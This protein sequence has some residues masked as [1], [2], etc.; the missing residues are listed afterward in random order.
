MSDKSLQKKSLKH[1]KMLNDTDKSGSIF[2]QCLL[3]P[4][5]KTV[6]GTHIHNLVKHLKIKHAEF[7]NQNIAMVKDKNYPLERQK[8]LQRFVEIVTV[9][10]RP[11]RYLLDSG[12][13]PFYETKLFKLKAAGYGINLIGDN[14]GVVKAEIRVMA[15]RIRELIERE[16][17]DKCISIMAD[18][19]TKNNKSFL[20]IDIQSVINGVVVCRSIGMVHLQKRHTSDYLLE[21]LNDCLKKYAI[22][23][24]QFVSMT[25]DNGRNMKKS[26]RDMN[27]LPSLLSTAP[28]DL[29]EVIDINFEVE[30][31]EV[32]I[33]K[34]V[35][36]SQQTDDQIIDEML[37]SD[38][39]TILLGEFAKKFHIEAGKEFLYINDVNCCV[40]TMQLVMKD[41]FKKLPKSDENIISLCRVGAKF[42]RKETTQQELKAA[43]IDIKQI[44][45]DV[46]TRFCSKIHMVSK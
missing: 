18:I 37:A 34:I 46:P 9:N 13:V 45:L 32:V 12:F 35:E 6:R 44:R 7:Y 38:D 30:D 27:E 24:S 16:V 36:N 28:I 10:G 20:G 40:H 29:E 14:F 17:K 2:Y 43:G 5:V 4:G 33:Q 1:F 23:V 22:N 19:G 21:V 39:Y 41:A 8:L 25:T 11:F 26:A 3:C 42:L 31:S 15:N